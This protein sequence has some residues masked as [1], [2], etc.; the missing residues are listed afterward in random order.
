MAA[1][2]ATQGKG[3]LP[4]LPLPKGSTNQNTDG[5]APTQGSTHVAQ[6]QR[7][8]LELSRD[9]SP[10]L[11]LLVARFHAIMLRSTV[12]FTRVILESGPAT[13]PRQQPHRLQSTLKGINEDWALMGP[14]VT[15][16]C[17]I[18]MVFPPHLVSGFPGR[19]FRKFQARFHEVHRPSE[20]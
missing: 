16:K 13:G 5:G 6:A 18:Q 12:P 17:L 3:H 19:G 11:I 9:H 14:N 15:S 8:S 20:A 1:M 7:S 2:R 10:E 4:P